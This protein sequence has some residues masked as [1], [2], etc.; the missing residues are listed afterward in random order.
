MDLSNL[1]YKV[2]R[3]KSGE[4]FI[5]T[6]LIVLFLLEGQMTVQYQGDRIG[7]RHGDILLINPGMNYELRDAGDAIYGTAVF[8]LRL[9]TQI[10]GHENMI[11]YANSAVDGRR[12]YQ[13]LRDIFLD[14]TAE[15]TVRSHR[16]DALLCSL[17]L[18]LLDTLIEN[19]QLHEGEI[20]VRED[21]SDSRMREMMRYIVA[22]VNDEISL[23]DLADSMYVSTSTLS[24]IFRK[25]TGV[26][27]A[28]YVMQLRVKSALGLLNYS[29]QNLTQIA[30][31]CGF[32]NSAAFN[33]A[34]RKIMGMTPSEYRTKTRALAE[35]SQKKQEE[36]E[37]EIRNILKEKGYQKARHGIRETVSIDLATLKPKPYRKVWDDV[38]NIGDMFEL[39]RANTQFHILQLQ[40]QLHFRYVRIWNVFSV[41]IQLSDGKTMGQYNYDVMDQ[42]LDFLVQHHL[43]PFLDLGRRPDM[44]IRI[45]G[46]AVYYEEEYIHFQ[47][48]T[49]WEEQVRSF[50]DEILHRYGEDEVSSWIFELSKDSGQYPSSADLYED[51][52]FDY[53][54]AWKFFYDTVKASLPE[55][56]AGGPSGIIDNDRHFF[57]LFFKKCVEKKCV[58]DFVSI[59]LF[60]YELEPKPEEDKTSGLS[61]DR[62]TVEARRVRQLQETMQEAG[63]G[64]RKL[65]ITEW[66]YS[67]SNR[68]YLNDSCFRSAYLTAITEELWGKADLTAVMA[69]TD[70]VS[71]YMD[72]RGI[73]NGGVGLLSR[74]TIRKPAFF[75][76]DFLNQLGPQFLS[77]GKR[78]IATGKEN[79]HLYILCFY[80]SWFERSREMAGDDIDLQKVLQMS[81][82]D[83]E[84]M[85][86]KVNLK[87]LKPGKKY[88][89][90]KRSLSR[91]SGSILDEWGKFGF[92]TKLSRSDIQYL[93]AISEPEIE[94]KRK[95]TDS[96]GSLTT[97]VQ[98]EPLEVV[99]LHIYPD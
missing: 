90:K 19:Y 18:R 66:N 14:I 30:M 61:S 51:P 52:H 99:L 13:D 42:V 29:D 43:K 38:I 50:L 10:M 68:N 91:K 4:A 85:Q 1:T 24:R 49:L 94:L 96:D 26:Y 56:L 17:L 11:L 74:D 72:T 64:D 70:W 40:E 95:W 31:N 58:P 97:D 92:D 12:S 22:H 6:D 25:K 54:N 7:M 87:G 35:E 98:L 81:F 71:S 83:E 45:D 39:T 5:Q 27:F 78:Y 86:L 84:P 28:D 82:T 34:F 76:I 46:E 59:Q 55:A 9:T 16:T 63:I 15:Y 67:I 89:I 23:T 62:E 53:F 60:P 37:N 8:P 2:T 93:R 75:A 73:L 44:A 32:S 36:E 79:G 80:F 48:R 33:R 88:S 3:A 69:G 57:E 65:F 21:E 41:K 77:S 20:S 47:S